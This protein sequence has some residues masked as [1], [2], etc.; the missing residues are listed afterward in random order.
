MQAP[1]LATRCWGMT[2]A[3]SPRPTGPAPPRSITLQPPASRSSRAAATSS[4]G[5]TPSLLRALPELFPLPGMF[6]S[7]PLPSSVCRSPVV[8]V[9]LKYRLLRAPHALGWI[10]VIVDG[11]STAYPSR[12]T[13][14]TA[15]IDA[16][17]MRLSVTV[18]LPDW[19]VGSMAPGPHSLV[20]HYIPST[21]YIVGS[22]QMFDE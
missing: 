8:K 21:W 15:G 7:R 5:L 9:W 13:L 10:P 20:S 11:L 6:S 1:G 12:R 17:F 22:Q 14:Q 2:F 3:C 18:C 19:N 4:G 16:L